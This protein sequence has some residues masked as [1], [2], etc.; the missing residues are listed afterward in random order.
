MILPCFQCIYFEGTK[1]RQQ[2][3]CSEIFSS[4]C[5]TDYKHFKQKISKIQQKLNKLKNII[6]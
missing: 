1:N 5:G 2:P 4:P 3:Y 6:V